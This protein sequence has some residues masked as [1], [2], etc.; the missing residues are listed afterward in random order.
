M[1]H[2][3]PK[4]PISVGELVAQ[5]LKL[6]QAAI[7]L[8]RGYEC[9]MEPSTSAIAMKTHKPGRQDWWEGSYH[10]FPED[11]EPEKVFNSVFIG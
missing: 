4:T 2:K 6:D 8:Q 3:E 9:G 10:T 5:L 1:A 7:V 11:Y